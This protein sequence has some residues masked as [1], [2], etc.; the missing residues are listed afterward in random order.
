MTVTEL[1]IPGVFLI[2]PQ[3]FSDSRGWFMETYNRLKTP[4]IECDFV[5]DNH[6][7]SSEKG[8]L[9]GIHFQYAPKAQAKLIRCVR[10]AINDYVVDLRPDSTS[11]RHWIA[12]ELTEDNK[13]MLLIPRGFGHAYV[14]L[15]SNTEVI[16]KADN[17]Y[18]PEHDGAVRWSDPQLGIDW[19]IKNPILSEKDKNA[20]FLDEIKL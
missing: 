3:V 19:G 1:D 6:A 9:R 8:V 20:P 12:I 4:Q 14:T 5:Q 13:E 15:E 10:G 16:Y 11:F 17:Y 18:S 7:Y 2:T